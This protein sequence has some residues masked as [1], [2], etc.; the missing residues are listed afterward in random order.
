MRL[1]GEVVLAAST[2]KGT[3]IITA[4][5]VPAILIATES[6]R[7]ISHS[8]HREKFG[9]TISLTRVPIAGSPS[10]IL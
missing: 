1:L 9:G 4:I 6:R 2:D 7:G 3:E 10:D 5:E 8:C